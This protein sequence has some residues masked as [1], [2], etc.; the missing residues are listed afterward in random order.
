MYLD[1]RLWRFTAGVRGRIAGAAFIG[2]LSAALGIARLA[3]AGWLI[4]AAIAGR[5]LYDLLALAAGVVAAVL[6]RAGIDHWRAVVAHRTAAAVQS[7][8]RLALHDHL[9]RLG[10]ARLGAARSGDIAVTLTEGVEQLQTYFGQYLP[11]L[12]VAAMTPVAIFAFLAVLDLPVACVM[13]AAALLTLAAPAALH[14]ANRNSAMAR[15]RAYKE[16]AAEFLDSIQGL[17]TLKAFGQSAARGRRLAEKAWRVHRAT[18]WVMGVGAATRLVTDLGIAAGAAAALILGAWRVADGAMPFA[19]LVVVLMLGIEVFRPL[20]ELRELLHAGMLGASSAEAVMELLALEPLVDDGK[21]PS[22][23]PQ[24]LAPTVEFEHVRFAYPGGRG[25]AHSDIDFAIAAGERVG[26]VGPSGC[27]KSTIMRLLLRFYDPQAGAVRLGGRDLRG[28]KLA[29]I[30]RHIAVVGQDTILFHGTVEDNIR[31]ARPKAAQEELEAAARAANA[32]GF[33]GRLP[34]GY[35]TVIGERGMRLSGGQRQ[36]IA[37][38]RALLRDAPILVLDEALSSVDAENEAVI[39]QALERLMRGRTTLI[40]AHRLS[41]VIGADRILALADGRVAE[42]GAHA[43]LMARRGVYYSLMREQARGDDRIVPDQIADAPREEAPSG[44]TA[45]AQGPADEVLRGRAMGWIEIIKSLFAM[46]RPWRW[47]IRA[48]VAL[49]IARVLA[50]IGVGVLGALIVQAVKTGA[51]TGSLIA[52]LAVLAP[53]AGFLH[54]GESWLAHEVAFQLLAEMRIALFKKL[55]ELAPAYLLRRRTGDLVAMATHD[56]EMVEYFFAHTLAPAAVAGLLPLAVLAALYALHSLLPLVL[57]P[58]LLGAA[59]QP[60][61]GRGRIDALGAESRVA[62][63]RLNAHAV[64]TIQGIG[65]IAAFQAEARRRV[66]VS[67]LSAELGDKRAQFM[68]DMSR[69]AVALDAL[70]VLGGLAVILAGAWIAASGGMAATLIPLAALLAMAAFLPVSEIAQVGRQLADTLGATQRLNEVHSEKP[71]VKEG[72]RDDAP[73]RPGVSALELQSVSFR[74]PSG[75]RPALSDVRF[76][77]PAGATVALVGPSGAGKTTIAHLLLR[78]Y[79]PDSGAIRM[80]GVD[81]RELKLAALRARIALVSQDTYL[82]NDDLE[83]NIRIGRPEAGA[84]E[85]ERAVERASLRPFVDALPDG[86]KTRVGERGMQLSG[87]QRQRV[88]IARALLK[89]SPVL[90]LD[91]ATSH[92][93]ALSER[94]VRAALDELKRDRTTIVIAHRLSTICDA[95]SIVVI[96][97]GRVREA[98]TH[99]ELV[100]RRGL[101]ARLIERQQESV[102][103]AE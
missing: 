87:G 101:Y 82:F 51:P 5:P 22:A 36:R 3:L 48:T 29:E 60:V 92:L 61:L 75:N 18:M 69:R 91:E 88:A 47:S 54:W 24:R 46:V 59:L 102:R 40:F 8:L 13:L 11:Q 56:V 79:D 72:A 27:G 68:A 2:L 20:R 86:L 34:Q 12:A 6:L 41:S 42:S 44:K 97:D 35:R 45:P 49:G 65:E 21:A 98:G 81:L 32:H 71:Q 66:E 57:L 93:D 28:L 85:V 1:R 31:L 39:Q 37:I 94:A 62:L 19:T 15:S 67:H 17:A 99:A 58:F 100:A 4:A 76:E 78:F 64:D 55:D 50:F 23:P 83:A 103:A 90:V 74:Y 25:A 95:A 53:L 84:A 26:I 33:I 38:A 14:G 73:P 63:G 9:M 89:D 16:F 10:P 96:D 70:T 80:N 30:R 43:E 7:T 52:T 77:V